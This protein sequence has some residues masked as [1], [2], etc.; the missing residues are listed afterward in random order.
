V[1][2]I[3]P[4]KNAHL[5]S[6]D[7]RHDLLSVA[8]LIDLCFAQYM[9]A[10]GRAYVR[11]IRR[12]AKDFRFLSW[13]AGAHENVSVPLHGY[14]WEEDGR[15]VGNLTLIPFLHKGTWLYLIANVAVHPDYRR[16]GIARQ[17]TERALEHVQEHGASEAWLQV[18][19][20]NQ[21]AYQLYLSLGFQERAWRATWH[22]ILPPPPAPT[23]PSTVTIQAH[24]KNDWEK[25]LGWLQE[26]YPPE[27]AWNLSFS[28]DRLR[29]SFWN[30]AMCFFSGRAIEHWT[31]CQYD[32]LIGVVTWEP[33]QFAQD[34]LWVATSTAWENLAIKVLLPYVQRSIHNGHT[35]VVNYPAGRANEAFKEAGFER[36]NVLVWME[37]KFK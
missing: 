15:I 3:L 12:A 13:T 18:R 31:A 11:H 33:T 29:P 20:E 23:S 4:A 7:V 37:V 30:S 21:N 36:Q 25:Q 24:Q 22:S 9:D 34:V 32:E 26:T 17:L 14:V 8:D 28:A 35:L 2:N 19:E 1:A 6:L 5:R 16:R 10:E 27:V